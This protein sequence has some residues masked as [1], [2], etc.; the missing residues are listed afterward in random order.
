M[1]QDKELERQSLSEDEIDNIVTAQADDD[2]AWEAPIEVKRNRSVIDELACFWDTHDVTDLE[3]ELEEVTEPVFASN[4]R[5]SV[6]VRLEFQEAKE[7]GE[8][9][10]A[11]GVERSALLREWVLEKLQESKC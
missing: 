9:A 5:M 3:D 4:L 6:L 2:S 11:R 1:S 10:K 7:V 8:I